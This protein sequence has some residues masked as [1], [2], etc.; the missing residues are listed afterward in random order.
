MIESE[1]NQEDEYKP[2]AFDNLYNRNPELYREIQARL[3]D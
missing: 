1:F 3:T 2:I